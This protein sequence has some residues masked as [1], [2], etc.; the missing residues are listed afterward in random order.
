[1]PKVSIIVPVY[2]VEQYIR[3]CLDSIKQ[4]TFTDWECLLIDDGSPDN[5]G[6]ICDEYAQAD[7]RFR[8]FHVANGGVSRARN[9]GLDNMIGEWV[10]FVD[11]DDAIAVNTLEE[12]LNQAVKNKLDILQF[13]FARDKNDLGKS[14]GVQTEIMNL[15]EYILAQKF[16]VCAGGSFMRATNIRKNNILFDT[17]L[18]LAED[19]LFM[20]NYMD[21]SSRFQRIED[22]FYYYRESPNSATSHQ[23]PVEVRKSIVKLSS[24]KADHPQWSAIIDKV[25][26]SFILS[27]ILSND[28]A[29]LEIR[30]ITRQADIQNTD[31]LTGSYR[32]FYNVSR[33][34]III[35]ILLIKLKFKF[36]GNV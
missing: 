5:S 6:K 20:Y 19:Q 24:F 3:E 21:Q 23:N 7:A 4:Q 14:N 13:S 28:V 29:I 11:S 35:A 34:N 26:V 27:L 33:I 17:N 1:M 16:L 32:L 22:Q 12:C 36:F 30:Q 9:I 8:V 18:K 31:R 25:L 15:N 2:K 10:M